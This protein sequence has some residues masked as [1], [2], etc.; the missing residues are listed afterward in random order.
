MG[1]VPFAVIVSDLDGTLLNSGDYSFDEAR[2]ALAILRERGIPVVQLD[3][4]RSLAVFAS[5]SYDYV[6]LSQT[7]HQVSQPDHLMHEILR[8][9]H[10]GILSFPNFGHY[11]L[12]LQLQ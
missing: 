3:L 11:A 6:I 2:P 10:K 4:N 9:G 12:R 8:I 7:I 1:E 5:D